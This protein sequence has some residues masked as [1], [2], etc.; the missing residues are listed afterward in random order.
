L[1]FSSNENCWREEEK[2]L[3]GY[4]YTLI[5]SI[6]SACYEAR[7]FLW[8]DLKWPVGDKRREGALGRRKN[9]PVFLEGSNGHCAPLAPS[10]SRVQLSRIHIFK[11]RRD[12]VITHK[13]HWCKI[14]HCLIAP[15]GICFCLAL[16]FLS[17][18]F[19]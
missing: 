16:T 7:K 14:R 9:W 18:F 8:V 17:F 6:G 2:K 10:G 3:F 12:K 19:V 1:P 15:R 13:E 4:E 5:N 11:P